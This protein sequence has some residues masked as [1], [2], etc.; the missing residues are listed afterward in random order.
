VSGTEPGSV[1]EYTPPI[2]IPPFPGEA[3]SYRLN[4]EV[5]VT[6]KIDGTHAIIQVMDDGRV[7]AG[8]KKRWLDTGQGEDNFGFARWVQTN[9][10]FL[11]DVL[12]PGVHRGEWYGQG[13][14]RNYGLKEKRLALFN[15]DRYVDRWEA[16]GRVGYQVV[17]EM[18]GIDLVPVLWN[19]PLLEV[20]DPRYGDSSEFYDLMHDLEYNGSR[21]RTAP[22]FRPVEGIVVYH[23]ASG[24]ALKYTL[25]KNDAHKGAA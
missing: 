14:Q 25:D 16:Q 11:A 7:Y 19:G 4:R 15:P 10:S 21:L 20:F 2:E 24:T 8:S 3:K 17:A 22:G 1:Y 23:Q 9:A 6:E 13:I 18:N 12:G 5:Q